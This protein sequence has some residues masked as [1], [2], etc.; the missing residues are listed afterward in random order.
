M[1]NKKSDNEL[2]QDSSNP[3]VS[4]QTKDD[5][6]KLAKQIE[7]GQLGND[8]S[9]QKITNELA[10]AIVELAKAVE[11]GSIGDKQLAG[12]LAIIVK[13]LR[14]DKEKHNLKQKKKQKSVLDIIVD[15]ILRSIARAKIMKK[16]NPDKTKEVG[17]VAKQMINDLDQAIAKLVNDPRLDSDVNS[18]RLIEDTI[19]VNQKVA[20]LTNKVCKSVKGMS[21][22]L[23]Q[24]RTVTSGQ[25]L[26]SNLSNLGSLKEARAF[27]SWSNANAIDYREKSGVNTEA[28]SVKLNHQSIINRFKTAEYDASL[29]SGPNDVPTTEQAKKQ[30][31]IENEK[32]VISQ[33]RKE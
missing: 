33:T 26:D 2:N 9:S 22:R 8:E 24:A 23:I 25:A 19:A 3:L 27:E 7:S 5:L 6:I 14:K 28:E 16:T 30:K 4:D 21:L 29:P 31:K 17:Y 18:I 12:Y 13:R 10:K 32:W 11:D 1:K 20:A 15:Q